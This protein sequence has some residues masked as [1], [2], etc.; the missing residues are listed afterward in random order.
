MKML[1]PPPWVLVFKGPK[2]QKN[3]FILFLCISSFLLGG[4]VCFIAKE[5]GRILK[6]EG[7]PFTRKSPGS[8]FKIVLSLMGFDSGVL[9]SL[10]EPKFPF[11][12]ERKARV[13]KWYSP[14]IFPHEIVW[15]QE[16]TPLSWM[17]CGVIW[18]SQEIASQLGFD[19]FSN[20]IEKFQYGNKD[21]SGPLL[22]VWL[23]NSLQISAVEQIELI[24]LL[25]RK[26][27]P[28]SLF[29]QEMTIQLMKLETLWNGWQLYG[30]TGGNGWFVGWIEKEDRRIEFVQVLEEEDP[31]TALG[32]LAKE[33]AKAHLTSLDL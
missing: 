19:R 7:A 25:N 12:E 22:E 1:L 14:E 23:L 27:L 13:G 15:D 26:Q 9:S 31:L 28:V 11:S 32:R 29:A 2:V 20:Y 30:R 16:H 17:Q 5:N 10:N 24:E 6:M 21:L 18:Y 4:E 3:F 33:L 8:T